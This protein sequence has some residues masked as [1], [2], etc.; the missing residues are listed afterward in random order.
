MSL[1]SEH[2]TCTSDPLKQEYYNDPSEFLK[3]LTKY[4]IEGTVVA[5]IAKWISSKKLELN[6][7]AIIGL[8]ASVTFLL[9]DIY[10]PSISMGYR[11]GIGLALGVKTII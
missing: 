11:N 10:S 6:E 8:T 3:K 5:V 7:I 4:V 2:K 9:L 1:I